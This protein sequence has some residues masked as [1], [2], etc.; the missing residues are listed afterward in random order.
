VGQ[1]LSHLFNFVS[2]VV[3][4]KFLEPR[5]FGII[6]ISHCLFGFVTILGD[7]KLGEA[8]IQKQ[9]RTEEA[10]NFL[11]WA[12]G[13]LSFLYFVIAF[14]LSKYIAVFYEES[15]LDGVIKALSVTILFGGLNN[16]QIIL[17]RKR[18]EL[19]R[20]N[21]FLILSHVA[22]LIVSVYLAVLGW[23]VWALVWGLLCQSF[24]YFVSLW[25]TCGWRPSFKFDLAMGRNLIGFGKKMTIYGIIMYIILH[26]D[27]AFIG[28]ILGSKQLGYYSLAFSL[29]NFF[30][31]NIV[32]VIQGILFSA[33]ARLQED[34]PRLRDAFYDSLR[35]IIFIILPAN[36]GL[37]LLAR[38]ITVVIYGEKWLPLVP[39][40]KV[41]CWFALFRSFLGFGNNIF[42]AKGEVNIVLRFAV[43]QLLILALIIYPLT[44]KFGIVGAA[45]A[46]TIAMACNVFW[47]L[48]CIK[49]SI[50]AETGRIVHIMK[51]PILATS[52]MA[53]VIYIFKI[54][55]PFTGLVPLC[56]F[57]TG[58]IIFYLGISF[59]LD[60]KLI[61][62]LWAMT[63]D[64]RP[65]L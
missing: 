42:L 8:A 4:S 60:H 9:E 1:S 54:F 61:Q 20:V 57:I 19:R 3:L 28:K 40:L 47:F 17:Y 12:C 50:G 51:V 24:F 33:Y 58:G 49:K 36:L 26:G 23:G 55:F 11:F 35:Y 37:F 43:R 34:I 30:A 15:L 39:A 2:I 29:S 53:V 62:E 27:A 65:P 46:M 38:E 22:K 13:G 41:L 64:L 16:V 25:L 63:G 21:L 18:L 5:D 7:F 6:A 31:F 56:A 45:L 52:G 32:G 48:K 59:I 10:A 44:V 14:F